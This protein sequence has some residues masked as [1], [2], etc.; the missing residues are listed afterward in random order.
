MGFNNVLGRFGED[1]ASAHLERAG[2]VILDRNWRCRAGEIDIVARDGRELVFV[3]VKTRSSAAFGSP[4]EAITPAK[5]ARLR[6]LALQ[7]LVER[8]AAAEASA[9]GDLRFDVVSVL[10]TTDGPQVEHVRGAF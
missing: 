5:A 2:C 1:L 6:S 10:R 3:E 9:Y 7:W 4:A 8:R